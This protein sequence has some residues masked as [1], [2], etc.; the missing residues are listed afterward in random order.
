[1]DWLTNSWWPFIIGG[2]LV[3]GLVELLIFLHKATIE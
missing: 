3:V 2:I 1:M